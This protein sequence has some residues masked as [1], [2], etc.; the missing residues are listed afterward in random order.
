MSTTAAL[1]TFPAPDDPP[2]AVVAQFCRDAFARLRAATT[3]EPEGK[4]RGGVG[5]GAFRVEIAEGGEESLYTTAVV[6][7]VPAVTARWLADVR[8]DAPFRLISCKLGLK[9]GSVE[10]IFSPRA[11]VGSWQ[12]APVRSP[13]FLRAMSIASVP[14][15]SQ[16]DALDFL[17]RQCASDEHV[18]VLSDVAAYALDLQ[19]DRSPPQLDLRFFRHAADSF[20]VSVRGFESLRAREL[21]MLLAAAPRHIRD[22]EVCFSGAVRSRVGRILQRAAASALAS[23]NDNSNNGDEPPEEEADILAI[24]MKRRLSRSGEADSAFR[25]GRETAAVRWVNSA[26]SSSVVNI[27]I[28]F[29]RRYSKRSLHELLHSDEGVAKR[30]AKRARAQKGVDAP[31][32]HM[33]VAMEKEKEEEEEGGGGVAGNPPPPVA[34]TWKFVVH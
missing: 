17:R 26:S 7:N 2:D 9:T 19:G 15:D 18:A 25:H 34:Q 29:P 12:V 4:S 8:R 16:R 32:T 23:P 13:D 1:P 14:K 5:G 31:A 10:L 30:G 21:D 6:H 11:E 24:A 28:C 33:G 27:E 3:A 22:V 20:F